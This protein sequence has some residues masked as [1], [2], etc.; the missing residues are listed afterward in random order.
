[1]NFRSHNP[2]YKKAL[3]ESEY[4][5]E[6]YEAA[7]YGGVTRKTI[8]Y[9]GMVLVGAFGGLA[10]MFTLPEVFVGAFLISLI[11]TIVLA[12][13]AM[14]FP[15]TTKITGTIYCL[16]EGMLVGVISLAFSL[17][18]PG[19]VLAALLSTVVV[20]AVVAT[21]FLTN[22]VKVTGRFIR[23][24]SIASI[25]VIISMLLLFIISWIMGLEFNPGLSLLISGIMVVL[26]TF[27][28]LFDMEMI[29]QVVEGGAPKY[30]EWFVSFGLVF[31][32]VWLYM[33]LLP[34][35]ARLFLDRN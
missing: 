23:F 17:E 11:A 22:V 6:T 15:K 9:I 5:A 24:L 1:M 21:L 18:A 33:E 31:T 32:I 34:L 19:V 8:F 28:L 35:L 7:S 27:Y 29:K 2:V 10:L 14:L 25:S 16:A 30:L 4:F 26:C 3:T 12:F 20:V 13:V